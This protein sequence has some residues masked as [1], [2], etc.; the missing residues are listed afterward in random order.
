MKKEPTLLY[1]INFDD[2]GSYSILSIESVNNQKLT[3]KDLQI[4]FE[5]IVKDLKREE[6]KTQQ[7]IITMP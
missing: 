7:I 5:Q 6:R 2:D 3:I 1:E 4:V